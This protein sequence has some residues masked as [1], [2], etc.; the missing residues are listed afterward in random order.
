MLLLSSLHVHEGYV[1]EQTEC[2]ECVAH[3]C[4]GH[5]TQAEISVD[6]CVLCQFLSLAFVS[7]SLA[8]FAVIFNVL[9]IHYAP[10]SGAVYNACRGAIITRGPPFVS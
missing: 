7:A 4:Q 5:L 10:L 2:A 3:H 6:A 8:A 9:W 1:A